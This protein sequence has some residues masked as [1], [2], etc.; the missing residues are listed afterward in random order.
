MPATYTVGD[1]K[2]YATIQ[3]AVDAIPGNLAGQGE[4]TVEIY[5]KA[6]SNS[7]TGADV[8]TGFTNPGATD[9]IRIQ[10]MISHG[11]LINVGVR[12]NTFINVAGTMYALYCCDYVII[13]M[14]EIGPYTFGANLRP[15]GSDWQITVT[16]V[17]MHDLVT[18][19]NNG[20]I[21]GIWAENNAVRGYYANNFFWNFS[22]QVG[23]GIIY[24]IY[25]DQ[26][27]K[28]YNNS[29]Y[30][31]TAN[32]A[33]GI[34]SNHASCVTENNIVAECDDEDFKWHAGIPAASTD[35]NISSDDT[36]D[37]RGGAN[38]QVNQN[39]ATDIQ[40]RN[41]GVGTEDLHIAYGSCA[42]DAGIDLSAEGFSDDID[43]QSRPFGSAWDVGADEVWPDPLVEGLAGSDTINDG[44]SLFEIVSPILP[45]KEMLS[46]DLT[47]LLNAGDDFELH[48]F[49]G[50]SGAT[51]EIAAYKI[52]SDGVDLII[53]K[54]DGL[55][56]RQ[57]LRRLETSDITLHLGEVTN[58]ARIRNSAND[59]DI[60]FNFWHTLDN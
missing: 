8:K 42:M 6:P 5:A 41:L 25:S 22:A 43:E 1:G 21:I 17:V 49:T 55:P 32:T 2:T 26:A 4:Q 45:I 10:G 52:T 50:P 12:I 48:I 39:P 59:R 9:F 24:C 19:L 20:I 29:V 31:M 35:N 3:A 14:L 7:Y 58:I 46:F 51:I 40:F 15:I 34:Y 16:N 28:I 37:D 33:Y 54:G 60:P 53:D 30:K 36:A 11:G 18:T 13:E 57:K 23:N 44:A 38:C 56:V 27:S 47:N